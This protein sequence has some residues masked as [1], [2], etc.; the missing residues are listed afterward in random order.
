[1]IL[2]RLLDA[3]DII[4]ELTIIHPPIVEVIAGHGG[5]VGE[6]DFAQAQRLRMSGVFGG[7]TGGMAAQRGVHVIIGRQHGWD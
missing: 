7:F 2:S 3:F 5:M 6:T 4:V 1:M